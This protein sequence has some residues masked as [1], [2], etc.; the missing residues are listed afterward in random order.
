MPYGELLEELIELLREDAEYFGC[1]DELEHGRKVLARGT[2]AHRQ[3]A[4]YHLALEDGA[5]R[6]E[7]LD[8]VVDW[9]I[10]ETVAGL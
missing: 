6:R 10:E 4:T 2:S 7:A 3:L 9:L 1:L 8:A 5:E